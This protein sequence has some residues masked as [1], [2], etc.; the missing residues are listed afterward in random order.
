VDEHVLTVFLLNEPVTLG[1]IEPL[2]FTS[3]Q[4]IASY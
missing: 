1:F 3:G 4:L 2:Y